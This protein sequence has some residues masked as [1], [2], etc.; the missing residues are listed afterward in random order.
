MPMRSVN[1]YVFMLLGFLFVSTSI[2]CGGGG[3]SKKPP[4]GIQMETNFSTGTG[5]AQV[6]ATAPPGQPV[7][8]SVTSGGK[9]IQGMLPGGATVQPGQ[10]VMVLS[11]TARIAGSL[12]P[13][14]SEPSA[15]KF[16]FALDDDPLVDTGFVMNQQSLL[17]QSSSR[18]PALPLIFPIRGPETIFKMRVNG[19]G[20]VLGTAGGHMT[21]KRWLELRIPVRVITRDGA[22][23]YM[24]LWGWGLSVVPVDGG[25]SSSLAFDFEINPSYADRIFKI[26]VGLLDGSEF[27]KQAPIYLRPSRY[28]LPVFGGLSGPPIAGACSFG[29]PIAGLPSDRLIDGPSNRLKIPKEGCDTFLISF[30]N[31]VGGS[32]PFESHAVCDGG[33]PAIISSPS[34]EDGQFISRLYADTS[35]L[36]AIPETGSIYVDG[37]RTSAFIDAHGTLHGQ[38]AVSESKESTI[39][40]VGPLWFAGEPHMPGA[41]CVGKSLRFILKGT[42]TGEDWKLPFPIS[43]SGVLPPLE[44]GGCTINAKWDPAF[45]GKRFHVSTDINGGGDSTVIKPDGTVSDFHPGMSAGDTGVEYLVFKVD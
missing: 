6:A 1:C 9:V 32:E 8:I 44:G 19:P 11:P 40:I 24:D 42:G 28:G 17:V 14:A 36:A 22:T 4:E 29:P 38:I 16:S 45:A 37:N 25:D 27:S 5:T 20:G 30:L 21:L 34:S 41:L 10:P 12:I 7:E 26:T 43:L 23:Q 18:I 39:D 35:E 31:R 15:G 13:D 2:G 33:N 3:G